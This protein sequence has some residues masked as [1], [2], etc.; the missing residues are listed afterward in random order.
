MRGLAASYRTR[1]WLHR[2]RVTPNSSFSI[3]L[4]EEGRRRRR[5]HLREEEREDGS[6]AVLLLSMLG[7]QRK[8]GT[9][10]REGGRKRGCVVAFDD[11]GAT[12]KAGVYERASGQ[13]LC[14][15]PTQATGK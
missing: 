3:I 4:K 12:A 11:A 15:I 14:T 8:R 5:C 6:M 13:C 7:R 2:L 10:M 9:T 1:F